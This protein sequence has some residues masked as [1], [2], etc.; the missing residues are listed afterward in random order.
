[1]VRLTEVTLRGESEEQEKWK[2]KLLINL[3]CNP[4]TSLIPSHTEPVQAR[5]L[6]WPF[7]TYHPTWPGV[8]SPG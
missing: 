7:M 1:M 5:S 6:C 2:E 4:K 8:M 3:R